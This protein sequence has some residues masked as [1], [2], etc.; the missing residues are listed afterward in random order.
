M[1]AFGVVLSQVTAITQQFSMIR[2]LRA[3]IVFR[4]TFFLNA[5]SNRWR[6]NT[7]RMMNCPTLSE[8]KKFECTRWPNLKRPMMHRILV[9]RASGKVEAIL[10]GRRTKQGIKEASISTITRRIFWKKDAILAQPV[11]RTRFQS[12]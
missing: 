5:K 9:T 4:V 10:T 12:A 3:R 7:D 6:Q 2:K 11:S 1:G 8:G